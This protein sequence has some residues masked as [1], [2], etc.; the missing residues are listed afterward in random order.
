MECIK[1]ELDLFQ[2]PIYQRMI[3]KSFIHEYDPTSQGSGVYTFTLPG[4][5]NT[6][7]DPSYVY[8]KVSGLITNANGQPIT[9]EK[10]IA[11]VNN[12]GHA[13]FKHI[14]IELASKIVQSG[15]LHYGYRSYIETLLNYGEDSK[16]SVL[17]T[18]IFHKDDAGV[19]DVIKLKQ[20]NG[21][22]VLLNSGFVQRAKIGRKKI[23]CFCKLHADIFFQ[24]KPL[25]NN[26]NM[27]IVF[28]LN[29]PEF[30]LI[31]SENGAKF[32]INDIKLYIRR[33]TLSSDVMNGHIAAWQ[34]GANAIY[35]IKRIALKMNNIPQ[36]TTSASYSLV[37]AGVLPIRMVVGLNLNE[38][39]TGKLSTNPFNFQ[40]F[41]LSEISVTFN[42]ESAPFNAL[43]INVD[44][45]DYFR[46]YHSL[47]SGIDKPVFITGNNISPYEWAKGNALMAYDF[48]PDHSSGDYHNAMHKG[49]LNVS[50]TFKKAVPAVI[51]F[52]AY[53]EFEDQIEITQD[54]TVLYEIT[55]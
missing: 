55:A 40:D 22:P 5:D 10:E 43:K 15:T 2:A 4:V 20:T 7:I 27:N 49:S 17:Q 47:F 8:Y 36:G 34:S 9:D 12:F 24:P 46:A 23:E 1:E 16:Q 28:T 21:E 54:R 45:N 25:P 3:K 41:D 6:Y 19:F 26:M 50:F 44:E 39:M 48:T 13:L 31:G 38:N 30:Y 18:Q 33:L 37:T 32:V 35:P 29:T 52:I 42:G 53:L 14:Q 51:N 11:P